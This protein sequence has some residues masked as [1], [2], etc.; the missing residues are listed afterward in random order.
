MTLATLTYLLKK[1]Y[2]IS[3]SIMRSSGGGLGF[4]VSESFSQSNVIYRKQHILVIFLCC[5]VMSSEL[6]LI[7]NVYK[8]I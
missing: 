1:W 4:G 3:L 2:L 5:F 7:H 6:L 8:Q